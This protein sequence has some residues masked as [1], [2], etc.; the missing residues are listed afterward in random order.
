M[1]TG[2]PLEETMRL[3]KEIIYTQPRNDK[4]RFR[5]DRQ[6]LENMASRTKNCVIQYNSVGSYSGPEK[7]FIKQIP[8]RKNICR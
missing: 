5:E 8:S 6:G 1:R 7:L 3:E 2:N 4:S